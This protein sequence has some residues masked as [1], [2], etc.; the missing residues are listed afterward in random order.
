MKT[1]FFVAVFFALMAFSSSAYVQAQSRLNDK[2][3]QRLLQNVKEDSQP[4]RKT[5]ADALKKSSIRK[6][7]REKDDKELANTFTKQADRAFEAF[8]HQ[9]RAEAEVTA[10][11]GTAQKI[12]AL[13]YSL[14]LGAPAQPSWE[15]LRTELHEVAQAFGV[16]EPYFESPAASIQPGSGTESCLTSAG[17]QRSAQLVEQCSQVTTSSH[18]PCDAKNTCSVIIEE[19]KRGCSLVARGAPRFCAEYPSPHGSNVPIAYQS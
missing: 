2:D 19:I 18:P 9:R 17:A 3:L 12:D 6:T 16:R 7:S 11:V 8:K 15:K 14:Q 10:L 13:V 5:F 4:F 1:R